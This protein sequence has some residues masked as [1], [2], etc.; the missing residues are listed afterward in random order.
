M[1]QIRVTVELTRIEGQDDYRIETDGP[2]GMVSLQEYQLPHIV[3]DAFKIWAR[4]QFEKAKDR[5]PDATV[6]VSLKF[7]HDNLVKL[8]GFFIEYGDAAA[9]VLDQMLKGK[10]LDIQCHPVENNAA[11][12]T[13]SNLLNKACDFRETINVEDILTIVPEQP[14]KKSVVEGSDY[15]SL[16][17]DNRNE[18]VIRADRKG[19]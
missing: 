10:W 3:K 16:E 1:N 7:E 9:E 17:N 2:N 5:R 12:V 15:V 8:L 19:E 14:T 6:T 13:L 11:M 18:D 4:Y